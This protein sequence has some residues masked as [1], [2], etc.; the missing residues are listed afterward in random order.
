M[1]KNKLRIIFAMLLC[2]LTFTFVSCNSNNSD[3]IS[4]VTLSVDNAAF[5][6]T[7]PHDTTFSGLI[8]TNR[9][10]TIQYIWERSTGNSATQTVDLP[11]GGGV[12]VQDVTHFTA[13]G[14]VTVTLHVTSPEN[15]HSTAVTATAT[16]Q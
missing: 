10:T 14:S 5:T 16:C 9:A 7:C 6:G 11:V 4:N 15:K 8:E 2:T 13:T 12:I 1:V 3:D